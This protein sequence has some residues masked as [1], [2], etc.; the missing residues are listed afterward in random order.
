MMSNAS[1]VGRNHGYRVYQKYLIYR[2]Q[3]AGD[4]HGGQWVVQTYHWGTPWADEHCPHF[5][6]IKE[7]QLEIDKRNNSETE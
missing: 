3:W 4:P 1:G 7:A 2:C 6:T 5:R